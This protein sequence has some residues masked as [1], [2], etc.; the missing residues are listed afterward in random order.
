MTADVE[1]LP[2]PKWMESFV[3]PGDAH[4]DQTLS[5]RMTAYALANVI[6]HT[7][8][9]RYA[10][11]NA[12]RSI[13]S[14]RGVM[15]SYAAEIERLRAER[16]SFQRVGTAA[17][18]RAERLAEALRLAMDWNWLDEDARPSRT[19]E[20]CDAALEQERRP[21]MAGDLIEYLRGVAENANL[22]QY[23]R[24]QRPT[25]DT[26]RRSNERHRPHDRRTTGVQRRKD[27]SVEAPIRRCCRLG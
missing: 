15:D 11:G 25:V 3:I 22:P 19:A 1:L 24:D 23:M 4:G 18:A 2:L 7:A 6:H 10:L 27:D 21:T 9:L 5:D 12:A 17:Q 8:P 16:D 20:I 14:L 13:K 26:N